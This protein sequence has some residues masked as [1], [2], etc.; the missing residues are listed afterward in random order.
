MGKGETGVCVEAQTGGGTGAD[1]ETGTDTGTGTDT[2]TD[3]DTD[4]HVLTYAHSHTCLCA[5]APDLQ[6]GA[7]RT[8][9]VF[10]VSL[11]LAFEDFETAYDG[12]VVLRG[13]RVAVQQPCH[14]SQGQALSSG[15]AL[16]GAAPAHVLT[17]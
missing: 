16:H 3:T 1:T 10:A 11:D 4:T 6:A 15:A 17:Y 9:T 7:G 2:D 14:A 12:R 13:R 8:V 5:C